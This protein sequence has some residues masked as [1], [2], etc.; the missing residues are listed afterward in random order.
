MDEFIAKNMIK[1]TM[2]IQQQNR[3]QSFV[4][5]VA[6]QDHF[7]FGKITAWVYNA[8]LLIFVIQQVGIL[9]DWVKCKCLER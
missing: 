8:T 3:L 7:L 2:G 4:F 6:L 5:D 9:L 1:M